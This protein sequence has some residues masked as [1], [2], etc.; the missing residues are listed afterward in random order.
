MKKKDVTT[1]VR[2]L[3]DVLPEGQSSLVKTFWTAT[4]EFLNS[5]FAR[6]SAAS[7]FVKDSFVGEYPKLLRLFKESCT[8]ISAP[9]NI[10]AQ[11]THRQNESMMLTDTISQFETEFL[12]RS[13]ERMFDPVRLVFPD[14]GR[15]PPSVDEVVNICKVGSGCR[16]CAHAYHLHLFYCFLGECVDSAQVCTYPHNGDLGVVHSQHDF[17]FG[18]RWRASPAAR[19]I[20]LCIPSASCALPD[21]YLMIVC[22][23]R[24]L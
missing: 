20:V 17:F 21:S 7:S 4:T 16:D 12:V 23:T 22:G 8:R 2:F 13:L 11:T 5:E 9:T 10:D 15:L 24:V 14:R 18:R 1:Q 6:I 3:D 19:V